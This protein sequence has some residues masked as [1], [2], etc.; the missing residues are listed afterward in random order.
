MRTEDEELRRKIEGLSFEESA[1]MDEF[2]NSIM[3]GSCPKCGSERTIDCDNPLEPIQDPT[4]GYC[5]DCGAYWC[6]ECGY[7]SEKLGK[8]VECPHW[9]ICHLCSVEH[10]YSEE[11]G[12]DGLEE[13]PYEYDILKCPKIKEWKEEA[14]NAEAEET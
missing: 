9:G 14:Q 3:V 6:L 2:V 7:V 4:V 13:C 11:G 12:L 5:F 1:E 8:G 10:N